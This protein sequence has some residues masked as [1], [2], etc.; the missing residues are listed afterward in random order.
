MP[1]I[2]VRCSVCGWRGNRAEIHHEDGGTVCP[3][4][5]SVTGLRLHP[6]LH[7]Q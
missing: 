6:A 7:Q 4:C 1:P 5:E 3:R 2:R